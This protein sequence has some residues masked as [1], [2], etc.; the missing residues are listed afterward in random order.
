MIAF[1]AGSASRAAIDVDA[2]LNEWGRMAGCS[3]AVEGGYRGAS[4]QTLLFEIL[5]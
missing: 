2:V 1:A 3:N 5:F 4:M